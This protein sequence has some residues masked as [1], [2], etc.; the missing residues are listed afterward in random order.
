LVV[1]LTNK[2]NINISLR[3]IKR[4]GEVVLFLSSYINKI[5]KKGRVSIPAQFRAALG[6]Q[7]FQGV[8]AYGS[9]I[10]DCV[11][12]CGVERIEYLNKTI[13]NL[14]PYSDARDAFATAILG[15]SIQLPFDKEGRVILPTEL[16]E[17]A[18]LEDQACFVGKGSTFEIWEPKKFHEYSKK[19]REIAKNN[20]AVLQS[21]REVK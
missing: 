15:G 6:N 21:M 14:D 3:W 2:F 1:L 4:I 5:D 12:A 10:N 19:A 8:I 17:I 9:F 18:N 13:D 7:S 11:E 20:R 16:V